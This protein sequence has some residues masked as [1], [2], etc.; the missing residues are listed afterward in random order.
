[1][2]ISFGLESHVFGMKPDLFW[3]IILNDVAGPNKD[4]AKSER[5][6]TFIIPDEYIVDGSSPRYPRT[7]KIFAAFVS[8]DWVFVLTDFAGLVRMHIKSQKAIWTR[9]DFAVG[10]L[11]C[12]SPV[13]PS[14]IP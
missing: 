8:K 13:F 4:P 2:V 12:T 11:V 1:M 6:R 14:S 9:Q 3:K 7:V 5:V 10:S